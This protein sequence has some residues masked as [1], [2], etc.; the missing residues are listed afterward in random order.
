MK[1]FVDNFIIFNDLSTHINKLGEC[2][3]ENVKLVWIQKKLHLLS[4]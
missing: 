3:L 4:I 1:I 2:F